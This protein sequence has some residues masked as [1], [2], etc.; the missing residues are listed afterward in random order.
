MPE[1]NRVGASRSVRLAPWLLI[2]GLVLFHALNNWL[3]LAENVTST[4][5]D[6]PRHLAWSLNYAHMLEKPALGSLFDV[7]TSDPIRPPLF[8]A[9]AAIWSASA[10]RA[11][12]GRIRDARR[13][14]LTRYRH[15]ASADRRPGQR[16]GGYAVVGVAASNVAVR[17]IG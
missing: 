6:Q 10:R 1:S 11:T 17:I 9:S 12:A 13:H 16:T 3:W 5:W 7:M 2:G 8:A 14:V 4:G 15:A